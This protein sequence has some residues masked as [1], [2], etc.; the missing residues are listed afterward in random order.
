MDQGI[1]HLG[2]TLKVEKVQ[3]MMKFR[4]AWLV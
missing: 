4:G 1:L 2:I 3:K